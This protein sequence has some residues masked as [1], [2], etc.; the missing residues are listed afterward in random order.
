MSRDAAALERELQELRNK[1]SG[2]DV[3]IAAIEIH[4]RFREIGKH[5]IEEKVLRLEIPS[6]YPLRPPQ[7]LVSD[8]RHWKKRDYR[9][10]KEWSPMAHINDV[11]EEFL[12]KDMPSEMEIIK[13]ERPRL[14]LDDALTITI[15]DVINEHSRRGGLLRLRE[16]ISEVFRRRGGLTPRDQ[17]EK[18]V[19]MLSARGLIPRI[20]ELPSG[21]KVLVCGELSDYGKTLEIA[22]EKGGEIGID[23]LI[24][25]GIPGGRAKLILEHMELMGIAVSYTDIAKG[26]RW[27]FPRFY[28]PAGAGEPPSP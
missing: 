23:D 12:K 4:V 6:D 3:R 11:V 27:I 5:E 21:E 17:I 9:C 18:A 1:Y 26:K 20:E 24:V 25:H 10:I 7:A 8:G 16:L 2:F 15:L 28:R 22:Q 19:N 13:I 14:S